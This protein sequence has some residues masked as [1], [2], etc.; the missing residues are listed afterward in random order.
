MDAC[1]NCNNF[2]KEGRGKS[3]DIYLR[4]VYWAARHVHQVFFNMYVL[5]EGRSQNLV[6]DQ[7]QVTSTL[8][9]CLNALGE[10]SG[11]ARFIKGYM[12]QVLH[13]ENVLRRIKDDERSRGTLS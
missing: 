8:R 12:G 10:S 4:G 13:H 3:D 7:E 6:G 9:N 2:V 5:S 1:R 11:D